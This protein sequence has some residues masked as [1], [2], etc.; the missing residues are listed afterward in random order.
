ML[1]G[2]YGFFGLIRHV[3]GRK[4]P[5]FIRNTYRRIFRNQHYVFRYIGCKGDIPHV[6]GMRIERYESQEDLP[7]T[8][9]DELLERHADDGRP[10]REILER[11]F[12]HHG[13]LWIIFMD[14]AVAGQCWYRRGKHFQHWFIPLEQNDIVIFGN[15]VFP[16]WRGRRISPAMMHQAI[17]EVLK[18]SGKAHLDIVQWNVPAL[19][20][21]ERSGFVKIGQGKALSE[22]DV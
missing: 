5:E 18:N 16:N 19:R 4:I 15:M 14:G 8:V 11:E 21:I 6:D 7:K 13:N 2:K 20:A 9:L 17:P 22:E 12:Q 3:I 1:I 10:Y